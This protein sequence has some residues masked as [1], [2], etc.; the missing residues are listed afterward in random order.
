MKIVNAT[1]AYRAVC[2]FESGTMLGAFS[3]EV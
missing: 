2:R 3:G 1:P